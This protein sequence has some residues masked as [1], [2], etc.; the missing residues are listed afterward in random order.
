MTKTSFFRKNWAFTK[1]FKLS[2]FFN[3]TIIILGIA[4]VCMITIINVAI[5]DYEIL[6]ITSTQFNATYTLWYERLIPLASWVS[7]ARTCNASVINLNEGVLQLC[8]AN[9]L[10]CLH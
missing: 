10:S 7:Q 6:P 9:H 1:P 2:I 4:W 3:V 5:V 8:T